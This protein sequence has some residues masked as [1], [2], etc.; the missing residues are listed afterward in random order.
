MTLLNTL[1]MTD[2]P[3]SL[4]EQLQAQRVQLETQIQDLETQLMRSKEGYLKVLGALEFA[5][6][7]DQQANSQEEA[8]AEESSAPE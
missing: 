5:A 6:I 8:P 1:V 2:A 4:V 7:Q 3:K